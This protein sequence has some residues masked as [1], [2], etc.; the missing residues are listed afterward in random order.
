MTE[1]E[2]VIVDIQSRLAFQED[3]LTELNGVIARQNREILEL[4]NEI[5][6]LKE[7]LKSV[8]ASIPGRREEEPPPPHY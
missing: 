7:G 6:E 2:K 4:K 3:T 5:K 1:N 8:V